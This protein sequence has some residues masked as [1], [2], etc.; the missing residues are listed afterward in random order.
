MSDVETLDNQGAVQLQCA[1]SIEPAV[2]VLIERGLSVICG[3]TDQ[4]GGNLL[5]RPRSLDCICSIDAADLIIDV[6]DFT[7]EIFLAAPP[8]TTQ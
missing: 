8:I 2:L 4:G 5:L 1:I 7:S 3:L 6:A